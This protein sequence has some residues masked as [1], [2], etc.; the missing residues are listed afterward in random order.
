MAF[1]FCIGKRLFS[2]VRKRTIKKISHIHSKSHGGA[3]HMNIRNYKTRTDY[4]RRKNVSVAGSWPIAI[5]IGYSGVKGFSPNCIFCFPSFARPRKGGLVEIGK[6]RA[7][8]I[9]YRGTDG[10]IWN[11]GELA[12]NSLR[13]DDVDDSLNTLYSRYRY[14]SAM[15]RVLAQT[16]MAMAMRSNELGAKG[17]KDHI[18]IQ[19]G[20]PA[21]YHSSDAEPLREALSGTHRFEVK[22]G[23]GDWT[24]YKFEVTSDNV[25]ITQ[26]PLGAYYS[27]CLGSDADMTPLGKK[28][29]R[30][31]ETVLLDGGFGTIDCCRVSAKTH[32]VLDKETFPGKAMMEIF[33]RTTEEIDQKYGMEIAVHAI[34]PF[35]ATG[36]VPVIDRRA[37]KQ[38]ERP[39]ED[40]LARH[41]YEVGE[42]LLD[43]MELAYNSF[44]GINYLALAG[45]T[46]SVW[47]DQIVKRYQDM[48]GLKV[49]KC[50]QNDNLPEIYDIVRGYYLFMVSALRRS[51]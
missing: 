27:I 23:D 51:K 16:G 24:E 14:D 12:N 48:S 10:V 21:K 4:I 20:L 1:L 41:T 43:R 17:E 40:M 5:D 8:D 7:S 13:P 28:I 2:C 50:S 38:K 3:N 25:R 32:D 34:Q 45:G 49:V 42:E 36:T 18:V 46:S 37:R 26:Q 29:Y 35:L 39:F 6:P 44:V 30:I 19:S 9:M 22:F 31:G 33:R 15:F 11:V 47:Y